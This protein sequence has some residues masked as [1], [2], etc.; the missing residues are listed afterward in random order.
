ML[1]L[2]RASIFRP[3]GS[4]VGNGLR[5]GS[6]ESVTQWGVQSMSMT[7]EA[8]YLQLGRLVAEMPDL[9]NGPITPE[10]NAWLGRAAA[11]VELTGDHANT[12]QLKV[13]AQNLG[14]AI[15]ERNA[16]IIAATVHQAL[17]KAELNAP[18]STQ[19][20]FI[21]AGHTF[22]AFAA[23]GKVFGTAKTDVLMVDPYAD[24]RALTDYA[25]L[26]PENITIRLLSDKASYKQSIKPAAARWTQQFGTARP[27]EVRLAPA[28]TLHDRLIL[29]DGTTAFALGQS[30][31]K[32][33]E[34]AHTSLVRMDQ[35]TAGLKIAA[36]VQ[37]W[38]AA[39]PI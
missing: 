37:T 38:Q 39:E 32:L 18:A 34:R 8:L 12:L 27:L 6:G 19:G 11:L 35:D 24:E 30:F 20:A 21:A 33:A 2:R 29:V 7:P 25:I 26:A 15:R 17:A 28:R 31:N 5:C 10:M 23:V 14:S 13:C 9:A 22:D 36:Y 3:S 1:V 4:V 16:Q